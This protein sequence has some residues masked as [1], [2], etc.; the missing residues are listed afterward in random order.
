MLPTFTEAMRKVLAQAQTEARHLNQEFV[1]TEHILLALLQVGH[2]DVARVLR[3]RHVDAD[4]V[5]SEISEFLPFSETPVQVKGDLPL[6][7]R[8]QKLIQTAVTKARAFHEPAVST[9]VFLLTVLEEGNPTLND[10]LGDAGTSSADLQA[11]L[12]E[13]P[14]PA[15]K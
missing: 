6:S 10:A 14:N 15:E 9:R 8:A 5:R 11:A 12:A 13:K 7:P 3:A 1:G 4:L 2:T